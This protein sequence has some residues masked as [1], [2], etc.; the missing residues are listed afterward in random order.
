M[1]LVARDLRPGE[2]EPLAQD[3]RQALAE[4][5]VDGVRLPVDGERELRHAS[6]PP[7]CRR[8]GSAGTSRARRRA[9]RPRRPISG[10]VRQRS[11]AAVEQLADLVQLALV[12]P[13]ALVACV[14]REPERAERVRLP[15]PE[16]RRRHREVLVDPRERERLRE[17]V[18]ALRLRRL[19]R[20]LAVGD[21]VRVR[22][23]AC[24][25]SAPR[26][27]RRSARCAARSAATR[28]AVRTDSRTRRRSAPAARAGRSSSRSI[29]LQT[30]VS[31]K[32]P[33]L[34]EKW[35]ARL[36]RSAMPACAMIS[37]ASGYASTSR[38]RWSRDRRQAAAAVDEDR[39]AALGRQREDGREPL[40]VEEELLRARMELDPARAEVEAASRLLDRP[41]V[42]REPDERD[43]PAVRARRELERPVVAGAE[44]GMPVGLVEAEH[45]A[46][47]DA[48]AGS[49]ADRAPRSARPSRRC[50]AEVDVGVEDVVSAGRSRAELVLPVGEQRRGAVERVLHPWNL[51]PRLSR[52]SARG[53]AR[54][55]PARARR[56]PTGGRG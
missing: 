1:S 27:A 16:Q 17:E 20:R 44:A 21:P 11:R 10:S 31:K 15:R 32:T 19:E 51:P 55:R 56:R 37:C 54:R 12:V 45:E 41:L 14:Q 30:E 38:C 9:P 8:G 43:E 29:G 40:V 22:V 13:F 39:H 6:S 48:V 35:P 52:R 26:R 3:V 28:A 23:R 36:A 46:A 25:G 49:S 2:P 4:R 47:R 18:L 50:R 5:R 24:R 53:S 7:G 42:E 33:R 34:P